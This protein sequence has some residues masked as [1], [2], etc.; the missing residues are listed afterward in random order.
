MVPPSVSSLTKTLVAVALLAVLTQ[1]SAVGATISVLAGTGSKGFAG[2]G[3]PAQDAQFSEP[4]GV[5]RGPDGAL[6][7][8]DTTN[9]RIRRIG[10]DG[11]I[12]TVAGTGE[13][14]WSGDGGPALS[15]QL[16]E[17]WEV[18]FDA[19][20]HL[21]WVER[22]SH[23]VRKLDL[24]TGI[25][26]TVAGCGR[27]GFGGDGQRATDALMNQPHSIAFDKHGDLFICDIRNHRIRVVNMSTGIITTFAGTGERRATA[28]GSPISDTPLNGPR[29]IDFDAE[30]NLWLVLREAHAVVKFDFR[31]DKIRRIAGT[32][33]Q[34]FSG[35]EGPAKE[36]FLNGPKGIYVAPDGA[37]YIADTE[38][39]AIR[40]IDPKAGT[41]H[42]VAG[43]AGKG[44]GPDGP[45]AK[46][47]LNRPHAV[48][49]DRDGA[50]IISDTLNQRLRAVRP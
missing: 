3:G 34:G 2:D 18:R 48:Y 8:C 37:V 10:A 38:N 17:P 7:L 30:G 13:A 46:C 50:I 31:E 25:V 22:L 41:I 42:A 23:T 9:H 49:V 27:S 47:R 40:R 26:T 4:S 28:D 15:A 21:Y 19:R 16:N 39:H 11:K 1:L 29:A 24:K 33:A 32:G 5:A 43:G 20:G 35:D 44:D 14:G 12:E 45:P 6:Y 36:A